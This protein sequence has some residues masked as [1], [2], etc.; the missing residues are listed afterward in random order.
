MGLALWQ[1]FG[2]TNQL[3]AGLALGACFEPP[4][5]AVEE[6][7]AEW[8]VLSRPFPDIRSLQAVEV[9]APRLA[10]KIEAYEAIPF[11]AALLDEA[12]W[13]DSNGDGTRDKMIDN[14]RTEAKFD[15]MIFS[16]SPSFRAVA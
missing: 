13:K 5:E 15:L 10:L 7:V 8:W 2:S 14:V 11:N 6:E 4:P 9:L 3:L 16:D 1:L 12:G